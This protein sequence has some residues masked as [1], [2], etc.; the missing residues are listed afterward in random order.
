M[1]K[2]SIKL[3]VCIILFFCC[4]DVSYSQI[5]VVVN[6]SNPVNNISTSELKQIYLGKKTIFPDGKNIVLAEYADLKEKFYN[7]LLGWSV[8]KVKKHWLSLIFSSTSSSAPKEFKRT[9]ELKDFI[10]KNEGAIAF[11]D[12][13]EVDKSLKILTIDGKKPVN[14]DYLFK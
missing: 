12:L 9:G 3:V 11:V 8:I 4:A 14:K 5:A 7:I 2:N 1:K 10:L 6:K 13:S